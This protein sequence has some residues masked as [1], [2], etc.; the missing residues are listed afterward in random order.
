[1]GNQTHINMATPSIAIRLASRQPASLPTMEDVKKKMKQAESRRSGLSAV[2][3][4]KFEA[5]KFYRAA[6]EEARAQLTQAKE[7]R[8][9]QQLK[10]IQQAD[11]RR[12]SLLQARTAKLAAAISHSRRAV[13]TCA[14]PTRPKPLPLKVDDRTLCSRCLRK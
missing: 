12:D 11:R 3:S 7:L 10:K 1:M 9:T 4:Q 8:A 6:A 13:N 14:Q 2:L 5:A